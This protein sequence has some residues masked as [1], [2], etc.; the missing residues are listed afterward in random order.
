[1]GAKI[2]ELVDA[3]ASRLLL[4]RAGETM[5][6]LGQSLPQATLT[7]A[8]PAGTLVVVRLRISPDQP[9]RLQR[10]RGRTAAPYSSATGLLFLAFGDAEWT[11]EIRLEHPFHE[12]GSRLWESPERLRDYLAEVRAEGFA[13]PPFS[14]QEALRVAAPVF[15]SDNHLVASLGVSI[16]WPESESPEGFAERVRRHLLPAAN[17]LA[18]TD[19]H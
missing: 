13:T 14:N 7:Y 17:A 15:D 19:A 5:R 12:H 18:G 3:Q 1:M 4:Q 6:D 10:P 8:E 9:R 16:P 11:E 2:D